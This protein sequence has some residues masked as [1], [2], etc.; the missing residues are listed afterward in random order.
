MV[1]AAAEG[2]GDDGMEGT[3][4]HLRENDTSREHGRHLGLCK[5]LMCKCSV[6]ILSL[7]SAEYYDVA[8]YYDVAPMYVHT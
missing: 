3:D 2:S 6:K 7:Y 1:E 4:E 5:R 8:K